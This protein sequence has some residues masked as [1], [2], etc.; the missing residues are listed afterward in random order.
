M[1]TENQAEATRQALRSWRKRATSVATDRDPLIRAAVVEAGLTKEEV[2][3][4][5]GLG[6]TTID[7][8]VAK[9]ASS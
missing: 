2:H 7:R 4:L 9:G 3:I 1:T 6:R 8:I 5:T